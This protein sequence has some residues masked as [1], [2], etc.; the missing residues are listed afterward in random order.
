MSPQTFQSFEIPPDQ[1]ELVALNLNSTPLTDP[2]IQSLFQTIKQNLK[3]EA[4]I[5][6]QNEKDTRTNN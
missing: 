5:Q 4:Q 6:L 3:L 1:L 2:I